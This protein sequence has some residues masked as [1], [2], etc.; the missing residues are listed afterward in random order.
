MKTSAPIGIY[1]PK[2]SAKTSLI[3][4]LKE[5]GVPENLLQEFDHEILPQ[6]DHQVI[7][8]MCT[9]SAKYWT[10]YMNVAAEIYPINSILPIVA[11]SDKETID[12]RI[13]NAPLGALAVD[14]RK[15]TLD[16]NITKLVSWLKFSDPIVSI[17]AHI[18][19]AYQTEK[20]KEKREEISKEKKS[21]KSK[22]DGGGWYQV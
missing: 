2:Y 14:A 10:E 17:N 3:N 19:C 22:P 4:K 21:Q 18:E 7:I 13:V 16:K 8:I 1:G 6:Q 9:R 20:E 15:K 11:C 5:S 12:A